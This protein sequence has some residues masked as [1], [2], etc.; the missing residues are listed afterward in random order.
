MDLKSSALYSNAIAFKRNDNIS[1]C[2]SF[3]GEFKIVEPY[4]APIYPI[5]HSSAKVTCVAY[6]DAGEKIPEKIMFK[7]KDRFNVYTNLTEDGGNIY[8]TGRTEGKVRR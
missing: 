3:S 8:F 2:L 1:L 6:D 7:R 4:P 5:E